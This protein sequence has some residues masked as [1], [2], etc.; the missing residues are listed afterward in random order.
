M[1]FS[2]DE[3][4]AA[5]GRH[6]ASAHRGGA[7]GSVQGGSGAHGS[8]GRIPSG[9]V[10]QSPRSSHVA[11]VRPVQGAAYPGWQGGQGGGYPSSNDEII[12]VRKKRKKHKKL[13]RA[14]L[15]AA[16]VLVVLVNTRSSVRRGTRARFPATWPWTSR[17]VRSLIRCSPPQ[18]ASRSR[19]T[20]C[21]WVPTTGKRTASAPTPWF[22]FA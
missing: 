1:G 7:R 16:I 20:C 15:V 13:K 4:Y 11:G 5:H 10:P 12:R 3:R 9:R 17:S 6:D 18:T 2:N 14:L 8:G 22:C 19:S 21:W